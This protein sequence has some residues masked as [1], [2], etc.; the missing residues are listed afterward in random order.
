MCYVFEQAG[1]QV[2]LNESG[3][4]VATAPEDEFKRIVAE[5]PEIMDSWDPEVGDRENKLCIIG[6]HMDKDDIVAKLDACLTDYV[7]ENDDY[8][9]DGE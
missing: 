9:E 6:R 2:R 1:H 5:S 8:P 3:L 7:P 4:W